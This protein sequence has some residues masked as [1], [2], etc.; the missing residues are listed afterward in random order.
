MSD[1]SSEE[2]EE[3]SQSD[4]VP[5]R[6]S[7]GV[8]VVNPPGLR[9][10][11]ADAE[12]LAD[13]AKTAIAESKTEFA[14]RFEKNGSTTHE[15]QLGQSDSSQEELSPAAQKA[16]CPVSAMLTGEE[17]ADKAFVNFATGI[18]TAIMSSVGMDLIEEYLGCVSCNVER[19]LTQS[20]FLNGPISKFCD[21]II[22]D[23][24]KEAHGQTAT[25]VD[26]AQ[27]SK[28]TQIGVATARSTAARSHNYLS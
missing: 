15:N 13:I 28:S 8:I 18:A 26:S 4:D 12:N 23:A 16:H 9:G 14:K 1:H 24:C 17:A 27:H 10:D 7:K 20:R 2:E 21:A 3:E 22:H 25:A 6:G 11:T 5:R 19:Q